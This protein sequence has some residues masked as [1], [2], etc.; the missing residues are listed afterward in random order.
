MISQPCYT[1]TMDHKGR[2]RRLREALSAQRLD[3]MLVTHL[4]NVLYLCGFTGSA[5]ILL[6]TESKSVFFTDGRYAVQSRAEVQASRI[7][8]A[9]NPR[10][11]RQ[12]SGWRRNTKA[13]AAQPL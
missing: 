4:P 8:I 7:V 2:Q 6:I 3:A 11:W 9:R 10:W 13:D 1:P 5:G 12:R